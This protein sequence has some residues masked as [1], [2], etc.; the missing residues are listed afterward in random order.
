MT[1]SRT[2][3]AGSEQDPVVPIDGSWPT[4]P[5]AEEPICMLIRWRVV[6]I[7][8]SLHFLGWHR[9]DGGGRISSKLVGLDPVVRG[10]I[11]ASGRIYLVDGPSGYDA[12][13]EYVLGRWLERS[14]R[15]AE[16]VLD[17]TAEVEELFSRAA[18]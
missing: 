1:E 18:R 15:R 3:G 6:E 9:A 5:V 17:V 12:D 14:S 4:R 8:A 16:D 2:N 13:A 11:T 7:A 10:G